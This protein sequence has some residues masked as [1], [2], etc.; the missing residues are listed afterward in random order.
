M[1]YW[2]RK[3]LRRGIA[4]V[5]LPTG[6]VRHHIRFTGIVEKLY[7]VAFIPGAVRP[8]LLGFKTNEIKHMI[9]PA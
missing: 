8:M 6:E 9:R 4:V 2:S 5:H 3:P 1:K 7:E